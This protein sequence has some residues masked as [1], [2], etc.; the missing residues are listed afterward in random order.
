MTYFDALETR[1]ADERASDQA[2]ALREQLKRV[3][4]APAFAAHLADADINAVGSA[5]DLPVLPVF[6]KSDLSRA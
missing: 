4:S 5:D 2:V 3:T 6:R 1:S